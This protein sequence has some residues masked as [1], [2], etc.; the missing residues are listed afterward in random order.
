MTV[1]HLEALNGAH[2]RV[3]RQLLESLIFEGVVM[4]FQRKEQVYCIHG[5][6]FEGKQVIYEFAARKRFTFGMLRLHDQP[7]L[8]E[9]RGVREEAV[10]I[11]LFLDEVFHKKSSFNVVQSSFYEELER[12]LVNEILYREYRSLNPQRFDGATLAELECRSEGHPYH[13]CFRSRIGFSD[14]DNFAYSP[15][16]EPD[17]TVF[18][19]AAINEDV[20]WSLNILK[21]GWN[22]FIQTTISSSE[23]DRFIA[24]LKEMQ[25]N[26]DRYCYV[27]V[28]PWQWEHYLKPSCIEAVEQL[29]L[30]P[31]GSSSTIYTPQQSI[32]T[33]SC[34]S[35]APSPDLKLSIH[36]MNTSSLR[37]LSIHSVAAAPAVSGWLQ[38]VVDRDFYLKEEVRL[39]LLHELAGISYVPSGGAASGIWRE[40]IHSYLENGE[41][42]APFHAFMTRDADGQSFIHAWLVQYGL[43][44]WFREWLRTSIIPV[45]HLLVARGIVLESHAQNMIMI[46]RDGWPVRV[47]L[48]DFHEGVEYFAPFLTDPDLVPDFAQIH[49]LYGEGEPGDYFE[50]PTLGSLQ[51]MMIDALWFMNVG[52]FIM[53]I[54]DQ[55][56]IE[57]RALWHIVVNELEAYGERHPELGPRL[58]ALDLFASDCEIEALAQKK[59]FG[60]V[61]LPP[62]RVVNPLHACKVE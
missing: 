51:E 45:V 37:D 18:W 25:L 4:P 3:L 32:R 21:L 52:Y 11:S 40:S 55:Y 5:I 56:S 38:A 24:C 13:P 15:E 22:E 48:R 19:L 54:A 60:T 58:D 33:L 49:P 7:I 34:R 59:L 26:P 39:I 17:V 46:H 14:E 41:E 6:D 28:H 12:T 1:V 62:R 23:K 20:V 53:N 44:K 8:R 27:P 47:A 36:I 57:E 31:L 43:D 42:A 30:I 29:R 35:S 50:M 16:Y 61:Q 9:S 10:N 2:R